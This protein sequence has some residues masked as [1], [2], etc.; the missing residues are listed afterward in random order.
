MNNK[1]FPNLLILLPLLAAGAAWADGDAGRYFFG[2]RAAGNDAGVGDPAAGLRRD[3]GDRRTLQFGFQSATG[4]YGTI[5]YVEQAGDG[6]GLSGATGPVGLSTRSL[7]INGLWDFKLGST[8]ITP[9]AGASLGRADQRSPA[10]D[11][12]G[13]DHGWGMQLMVGLGVKLTPA[14]GLH[15]DLRHQRNAGSLS[16]PFSSCPPLRSALCSQP[17]SSIAAPNQA[18]INNRLGV[19]L[20]WSF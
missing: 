7:T 4:P 8:A 12:D 20:D 16:L 10:L 19:G 18:I 3:A 11:G 1:L 5:E 9:F 13:G 14:L 6:Q 2:L 17:G 15:L